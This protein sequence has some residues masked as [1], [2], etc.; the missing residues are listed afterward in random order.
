MEF[1]LEQDIFNPLYPP[2]NDPTRR[3]SSPASPGSSTNGSDQTLVSTRESLT[4]GSATMVDNL[5]SSGSS[6][7]PS[8]AAGERVSQAPWA[9]TT[10]PSLSGLDGTDDWSP[11]AE[12]I[13]ES[14]TSRAKPIPALE[15]LRRMTHAE[16]DGSSTPEDPSSSPGM[17]TS[18]TVNSNARRLRRRAGRRNGGVGMMD[19][20]AVMAQINEQ[21]GM[22]PDLD[23]FLKV[24]VGVLKDLTQFHRVMVYQFDEVWNGQVVAELLDWSKT[25]DLFRGLHFP[26]GDIPAQVSFKKIPFVLPTYWDGRRHES[27]MRLVSSYLCSAFL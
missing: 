12:D 22:A 1:E 10:P 16:A 24:V 2:L 4:S 9:P 27:F 7:S 26:A 15:R 20:F 19:V 6:R 21:L 18:P 8:S 23:M 17:P 25:H 5:S 11:S 14:T 13:F 3:S